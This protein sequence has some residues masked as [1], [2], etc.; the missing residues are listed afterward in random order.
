MSD[1]LNLAQF[2]L[3]VLE[4]SRAEGL[5]VSLVNFG[6]AVFLKE[7]SGLLLHFLGHAAGTLGRDVQQDEAA[8]QHIWEGPGLKDDTER[9]KEAFA[10]EPQTPAQHALGTRRLTCRAF[11]G[12]AEPFLAQCLVI[13]GERAGPQGWGGC[14]GALLQQMRPN[15]HLE[16][17][18]NSFKRFCFYYYWGRMQVQ[19]PI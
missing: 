17:C 10:E 2:I 1:I 11:S 12:T 7:L 3:K 13:Y 14:W 19:P 9:N 8:L 16:L 5:V 18:A 6:V 15:L 4:S